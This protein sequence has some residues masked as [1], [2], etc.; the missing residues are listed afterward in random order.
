MD[1]SKKL[2]STNKQLFVSKLHIILLIER[3]KWRKTKRFGAGVTK[4]EGLGEVLEQGDRR[5]KDWNW[6]IQEKGWPYLHD[7]HIDEKTIW[8]KSI[9][10]S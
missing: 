5:P 1:L 6:I 9:Y 10:I 8:L 2:D 3:R 4:S 7:G